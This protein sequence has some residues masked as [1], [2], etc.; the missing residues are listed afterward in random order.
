MENDYNIINGCLRSPFRMIAAGP[1]SSGKTT[2]VCDLLKNKEA[3]IDDN[4]DYIVWFF[5]QSRP[6]YDFSN[7]N[8]EF[9]RGLPDVFDGYIIEGKTGLF[10][11]DDLISE[12][13]DSSLI[14]D[15]FTKRSHHD[16]I[17]IIFITQNF[18]QKGSNRITMAKNCTYIVLFNNPL[19][20]SISYSFAKKLMPQN[21]K[22]FI[23]IYNNALSMPHGYIFLDGSQKSDLNMRFRTDL[24]NKSNIQRVFIPN[25]K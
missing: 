20:K 4:I 23:D 8:I 13:S 21:Q 6:N 11:F 12:A 14:S 1:S 18:F 24:I 19:D 7:E 22:C 25:K 2:F 16:N 10:V 9:V 3:M 17:N 15:F 5:G